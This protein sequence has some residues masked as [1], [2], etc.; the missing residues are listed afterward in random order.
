MVKVLEEIEAF[1]M[2]PEL[3]VATLVTTLVPREMVVEVPTKI[4]LPSPLVKLK[5]EPKAKLPK[6]VVPRPP[7]ED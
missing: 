3:P 7:L 5:L 2:L 4:I 1:K 6:V